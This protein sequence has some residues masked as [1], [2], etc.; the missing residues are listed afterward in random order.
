MQPDRSQEDKAEPCCRRLPAERSPAQI[1]FAGS[2][3]QPRAPADTAAHT[4]PPASSTRVESILSRIILKAY[5]C[6]HRPGLPL[7]CHRSVSASTASI[8]SATPSSS[9]RRPTVH[10]RSCASLLQII[11]S[12]AHQHLPSG[13][14]Q[15][16]DVVPVVSDGQN[17]LGLHAAIC[18]QPQQ[19]RSLAASRRQYV[20]NAQIPLRILRPVQ[21][22]LGYAT[23][24]PA[25][26]PPRQT[27]PDAPADRASARR[28]RSIVPHSII[29][30]GA[31][32]SSALSIG[33][34]CAM[35]GSF[36]AIH[37]PMLPFNSSRCS[38]TR[39]PRAVLAV[40]SH[41]VEG[42]HQRVAKLLDVLA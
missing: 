14:L 21:R 2:H 1:R 7:S 13:H 38:T 39:A 27:L 24:A 10:P 35:Y 32:A 15:H 40:G 26:S 34:T 4:P 3:A 31:S 20:H 42:D 12:V 33:T 36:A 22:N 30:M 28:I 29:W 11:R 17:L 23:C 25:D 9:C 8:A 18:R 5:H 6:P 41:H 19:R 16:G 37:L